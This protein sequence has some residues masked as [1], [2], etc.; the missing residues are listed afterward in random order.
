MFFDLLQMITPTND[1]DNYFQSIISYVVL[2]ILWTYIPILI[3]LLIHLKNVVSVNRLLKLQK[4][5]NKE[6][7]NVGITSEEMEYM[8]KRQSGNS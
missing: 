1:G 8:I 6:I 3:V 7:K 4:K 2:P 5:A